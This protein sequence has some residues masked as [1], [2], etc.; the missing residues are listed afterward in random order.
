M[1]AR[2]AEGEK[3]DMTGLK[4]IASFLRETAPISD[5]KRESWHSV[6]KVPVSQG[7]L[8][9]RYFKVGGR[10]AARNPSP[11]EGIRNRQPKT[12][13]TVN[14]AQRISKSGKLS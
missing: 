11:Y 2:D 3:N 1:Q 6:K 5:A 14:S 7:K 12:V 4:D 13:R 10:K 8:V 9:K